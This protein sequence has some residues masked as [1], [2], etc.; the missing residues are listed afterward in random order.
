MKRFLSQRSSPIPLLLAPLLLAGCS[1]GTQTAPV[2]HA[3]VTVADATVDFDALRCSRTQIYISVAGISQPAEF[4]AVFDISGAKPVVAW[5]KIRDVAG[6]SGDVWRGGV[7]S[8]D[9]VRRDREYVV[10]GSAYGVDGTHPTDLG[11]TVPFR[12]RARC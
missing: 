9:A 10:T 11:I 12:I 1:A 7:G 5:V 2:D 3:T 6:F 4:T 8:A